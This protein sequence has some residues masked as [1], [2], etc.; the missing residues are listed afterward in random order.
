MTPPPPARSLD[1]GHQQV[2]SA[3]PVAVL[4]STASVQV[5]PQTQGLPFHNPET[6]SFFLSAPGAPGTCTLLLSRRLQGWEAGATG[7]R[8]LP[9]QGQQRPA[10]LTVC[11]CPRM[12]GLARNT[13]SRLAI[14]ESTA[15]EK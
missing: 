8:M 6:D 9:G 4:T 12:W 15:E 3:C 2:P 7:R 11:V 5:P 14:K 10:E 1:L 13:S